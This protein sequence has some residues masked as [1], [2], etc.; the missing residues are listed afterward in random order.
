MKRVILVAVALV[1]SFAAA[2]AQQEERHSQGV[3]TETTTVT[4]TKIEK[5][6][7]KSGTDVPQYRAKVGFQ[8]EV[9]M[10]WWWS[11][12]TYQALMVNYI[13]GYRFN[14]IFFVGVG[15][16]LNIGIS[17]TGK[18]LTYYH[19]WP[20]TEYLPMQ[21]ISVPLFVNV[22][23][24]LIKK[25]VSPYM[26]FSTGARFSTPKIVN[27]NFYN[28]SFYTTYPRIT[29]FIDFSFGLNFCGSE[30]VRYNLQVGYYAH[31][32]KVTEGVIEN[33]HNRLSHGVSL[34]FGVE[35]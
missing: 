8:Q 12:G 18:W 2:E 16:G 34:L 5:K 17:K 26:S 20:Y 4:R 23:G 32:V 29:P 10:G 22:K 30:N 19:D 31:L 27:C 3:F 15:A 14:D 7:E 28:H 6:R 1:L 13:G 35:F 11:K 25:K 24:Y 9:S 21:R 33:F